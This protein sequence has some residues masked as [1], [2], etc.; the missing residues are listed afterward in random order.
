M[1]G[2]EAEAFC[3]IKCPICQNESSILKPFAERGSEKLDL[4]RC[5]S[6][7]QEFL[8]PYPSDEWLT[9]EYS[10]Y[11]VKRQAGSTGDKVDY[12]YGLFQSLG[13]KFQNSKVLEF[14]PGE[15]DAIQ[16]LLKLGNPS[17]ITV[18]ERN[19]EANS[20]LT[21]FECNHF[22]MFLEEYL[23]TEK[24]KF[25]YIFL[26]D[27]LEHLKDPVGVLKKIQENCL[28]PRGL[29]VATFPVA[30]SLS[31]KVLKGLWPQFKVEHLQYFSQRSIAEMARASNLNLVQNEVL[32][33]KLSAGYLLN[34]GKGF[35]PKKFQSITRG[36]D[37][38]TP[39][40]LKKLNVT[41]GY[42]E[43]LV[44]FQN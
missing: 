32:Y 12:F 22:N 36:V 43:R 40:Q 26:F 28:N 15:G 41:L 11:Y 29:V 18:V 2:L 35:G 42:G 20:L 19:D 10:Q 34:V 37:K 4:C 33:K 8:H 1:G 17:Q 30:D 38:V 21:R 24:E 27:V 14:G 23:E 44:L 9:E 25:D 3:M 5:K 16:A 7:E 39:S 13:L 6:C 31:R